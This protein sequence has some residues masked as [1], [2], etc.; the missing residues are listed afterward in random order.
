MD[1][2]PETQPPSVQ[3]VRVSCEEWLV[4][5]RQNRERVGLR[6]NDDV[7]IVEMLRSYDGYIQCHAPNAAPSTP[8]TPSTQEVGRLV[9]ES[10]DLCDALQDVNC[11][12]FDAANEQVAYRI[13]DSLRGIIETLAPFRKDN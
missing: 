3:P 12:L 5:W 11:D 10:K 8:S 6:T 4:R 1:D 13:S 9:K 7:A 2:V